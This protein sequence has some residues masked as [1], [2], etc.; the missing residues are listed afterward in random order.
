[1]LE[2]KNFRKQQKNG[3]KIIK[4]IILIILLLFISLF[5]NTNKSKATTIS[6][7][8]YYNSMWHYK[9]NGYDNAN[10]FCAQEGG[11]LSHFH[12]YTYTNSEF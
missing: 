10:L 5:I 11:P 4:K 12:A 7:G 1:M 9:I 6:L 3:I 2:F 8:S